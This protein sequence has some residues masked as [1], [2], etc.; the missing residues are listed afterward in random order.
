MFL[1]IVMSVTVMAV[2]ACATSETVPLYHLSGL[3][4]AVFSPDGRRAAVA[5]FNTIWIL[6][7]DSMKKVMSFSGY[8]RYGTNNTLAFIGREAED[9][10]VLIECELPDELPELRLDK[11]QIRQ[12]MYN[13]VRNAGNDDDRQYPG[14]ADRHP[15][16][17]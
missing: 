3:S 6:D 4:A 10:G 15:S 1:R 5:N 9:R 17:Q 14:T 8:Y 11:G 2:V 12:A 7:T 16:F 13:L